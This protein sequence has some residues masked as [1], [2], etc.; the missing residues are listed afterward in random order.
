MRKRFQKVFETNPNPPESQGLN[1]SGQLEAAGDEPSK[2]NQ[3]LEQLM[4]PSIIAL[5]IPVIAIVMG[6]S[7]GGVVIFLNYRKRKEM[8]AL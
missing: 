6:I 1:K 5:F 4:G 8:F 7:L 3:T 2:R